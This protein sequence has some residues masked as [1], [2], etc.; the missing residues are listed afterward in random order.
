MFLAVFRPDKDRFA[1]PST[2]F[3]QGVK[4]CS[5][6]RERPNERINSQE[7]GRRTSKVES[8]TRN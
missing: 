4:H 7:N 1:F 5:I 6:A 8:P 3:G 2:G